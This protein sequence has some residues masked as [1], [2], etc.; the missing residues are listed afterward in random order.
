MSSQQNRDSNM[1]SNCTRHSLIY[2]SEVFHAVACRAAWHPGKQMCR[3]SLATLDYFESRGTSP[4]LPRRAEISASYV[5]NVSSSLP[6]C[7]TYQLI[8]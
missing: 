8:M 5:I 7:I 1:Y 4:Y 6:M 2:S 3:A